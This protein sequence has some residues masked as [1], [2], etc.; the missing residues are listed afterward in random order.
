MN[1]LPSS[2]ASPERPIVFPKP[3]P[4][5]ATLFEVHDVAINA[6]DFWMWNEQMKSRAGL[7]Q[8][9]FDRGVYRG[10]IVAFWGDPHEMSAAETEVVQTL[11]A[12][13]ELAAS[14]SV[15]SGT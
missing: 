12:L 6:D 14:G 10:N 3:R 9:V 2:K 15:T 1:V 5:D 7:I 13:L 4:D 11:G 8:G